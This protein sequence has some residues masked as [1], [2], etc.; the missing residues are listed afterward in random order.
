VRLEAFQV[1]EVYDLP[2]AL[3]SYLVITA[4]ALPADVTGARF[5]PFETRIDMSPTMRPI[6]ADRSRPRRKSP[7]RS[8]S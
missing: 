6:A 1:G 7:R 5:F 8:T 4:S 2:A 3:G